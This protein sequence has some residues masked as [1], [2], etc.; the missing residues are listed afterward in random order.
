VIR[1]QDRGPGLSHPAERLTRLMPVAQLLGHHAQ[2]EG[3]LQ[4]ERI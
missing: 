2:I 1:A 4:H 3:D